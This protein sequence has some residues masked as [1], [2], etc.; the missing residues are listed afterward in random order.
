MLMDDTLLIM[1]YLTFETINLI[2][3]VF[4]TKMLNRKIRNT[5]NQ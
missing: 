5:I 3:A 4:I 2:H 1:D